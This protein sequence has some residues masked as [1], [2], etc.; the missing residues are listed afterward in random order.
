MSITG[1]RPRRIEGV[2]GWDRRVEE[3]ESRATG[4]FNWGEGGRGEEGCEG[5]RERQ[6]GLVEYID[7]LQLHVFS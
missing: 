4:R 6:F 7:R 3:G 1:T 2:R 5:V